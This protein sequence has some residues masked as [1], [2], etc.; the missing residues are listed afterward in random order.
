MTT[1]NKDQLIE[2][3]INKYF[4][5]CSKT[6]DAPDKFKDI[7]RTSITLPEAVNI[8]NELYE[9]FSPIFNNIDDGCAQRSKLIANYL[10]NKDISPKRLWM[11]HDILGKTLKGTLI[12]Q[13]YHWLYH[14]ATTVNIDN[15]EQPVIL[16]PSLFDGPVRLEQYIDCF[17]DFRNEI[18][19]T[20]TDYDKM[21]RS[22]HSCK[23][24][25]LSTENAELDKEIL[26]ENSGFNKEPLLPS[27][28]LKEFLKSQKT[29][30][31]I[32]VKATN[33]PATNQ[34]LTLNS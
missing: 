29:A 2:K 25:F 28:L 34:S 33:K 26:E 30:K 6:P 32:I 27:K 14:T 16:D 19:Y 15:E 10:I 18:K 22:F 24:Y 8:F 23:N 20:V 13:K 3:T 9:E 31:R 11:G 1:D 7:S 5:I 4:N 17:R 12:N 21:W